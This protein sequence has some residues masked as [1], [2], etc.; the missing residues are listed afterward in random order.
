MDPVADITV[1]AALALLFALA[2]MHKLWDMAGFRTALAGYR[3][4]PTR[5]VGAAAATLAGAELL[6]VALLAGSAAWRSAGPMVAAMLLLLYG[7]AVAVNLV[8]GRR[9]IDCGCGRP[10]ARRPLSGWLLARN[11]TLAAAALVVLLPV[12]PR[13]LLW[14]DALT[15]AGA[16]A[17]L[18]I[19]YAATER[20]LVNLPGMARVRGAT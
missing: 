15:V 20:L 19:M 8:R 16:V 3:L 18:A 10:G 13:P 4:V 6:T 7:G 2:T 9:D 1:R 12:T 14:L 17:G 11:A 5:L